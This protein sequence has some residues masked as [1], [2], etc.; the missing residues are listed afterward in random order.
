MRSISE[1][2]IHLREDSALSFEVALSFFDDAELCILGKE[3]KDEEGSHLIHYAI[4]AL[5]RKLAILYQPF[6]HKKSV[7]CHLLPYDNAKICTDSCLLLV[8]KMLEIDISPEP[9][10]NGVKPLDLLRAASV[11]VYFNMK[12]VF[13]EYLPLFEKRGALY[14]GRKYIS[15]FNFFRSSK[16][17]WK[18][19]AIPDAF[20]MLDRHD[21]AKLT[22]HERL[23]LSERNIRRGYTGGA[24]NL[25]V[26]N[27]GFIISDLPKAA[28]E[29]KPV[30]IT[31]PICIDN[32]QCFAEGQL[33]KGTHSEAALCYVLKAGPHLRNLLRDLKALHPYVLGQKVYSIVL[34]IHS[35]A[36]VCKDCQG[37]LHG[38]QT[39]YD[40]NSFLKQLEILFSAEGYILPRKSYV[41]KQENSSYPKLRLTLRASGIDN[42][43]YHGDDSSD[44]MPAV[45]NEEPPSDI[46][47]HPQ[48]VFFHLPPTWNKYSVTSDFAS[49]DD[50]EKMSTYKSQHRS[51]LHQVL[52]NRGLNNPHSLTKEEKE[53]SEQAKKEVIE[54]MNTEFPTRFPMHKFSLYCQT[55][56]S[57]TGGRASSVRNAKIKK[58][59]SLDVDTQEMNDIF[60]GFSV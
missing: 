30:F 47:Y 16:K 3:Y 40:E 23:A 33:F 60:Y 1:L 2:I 44:I 24:I 12:E 38:L 6:E 52:P 39:D 35:T 51:L 9:N 15:D 21:S 8:K 29:H 59:E 17:E 37:R 42:P 13:Q 43:G 19:C 36:E 34:D 53:Q 25:V 5:G 31:I 41:D 22:L 10:F 4:Q 56:F 27:L 11:S 18:V 48:K 46:K 57:N 50:R 14:A 45:F 32:Y 49:F 26:A 55:A 28:P 7:Y 20:P 58:L 54:L